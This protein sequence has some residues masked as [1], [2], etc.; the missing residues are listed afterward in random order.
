[1]SD[2]SDFLDSF[3]PPDP[4]A[5]IPSFDESSLVPSGVISAPVA[6]Q[7]SGAGILSDLGTLVHSATA[8]LTQFYADQAAIARAKGQTAIVNAQTA[9]AVQAAR[10][11][12]PSPYFLLAAGVGV[13]ALVMASK[14]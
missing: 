11:G 10:A 2:V 14:R 3:V 8:P 12:Q 9:N 6:I 13:L 7:P 1:M 4:S 5:M